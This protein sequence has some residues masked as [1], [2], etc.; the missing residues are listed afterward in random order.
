LKPTIISMV[1]V[2]VREDSVV[3][4]G[5]ANLGDKVLC[6]HFDRLNHLSSLMLKIC[7]AHGASSRSERASISDY[8]DPCL[9][10]P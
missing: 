3:H 2:T 1:K 4:R 7:H 8:D 10:Y 5:L 6:D 9:S